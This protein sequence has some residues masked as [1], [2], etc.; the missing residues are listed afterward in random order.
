MPSYLYTFETFFELEYTHSEV[1]KGYLSVYLVEFF[2]GWTGLANLCYK[3]VKNLMLKMKSRSLI[4]CFAL[5]PFVCVS[6]VF[7]SGTTH[8]TLLHVTGGMYLAIFITML[9]VKRV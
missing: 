3:C 6:A 2:H 8:Q 4:R 5:P 9:Q 7:A 1:H